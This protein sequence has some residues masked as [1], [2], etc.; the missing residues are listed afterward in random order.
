MPKKK[1]RIINDDDGAKVTLPRLLSD[2]VKIHA[3]TID[4]HK[5]ENSAKKIQ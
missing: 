5:H 2:G 4:R 3:E 1:K